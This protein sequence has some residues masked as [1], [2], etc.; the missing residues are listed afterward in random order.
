MVRRLA[1]LVLLL[2]PL[3]VVAAE[4]KAKKG[5]LG[6]MIS[7]GKDKGTILILAVVPDSP[8]Q[9]AGLKPNDLLVRIDG[10]KP[11]GLQAAVKVIQ[12]LKPGKKVKFEISRDGKPK[13]I[14]VVPGEVPG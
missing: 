10:A 2:L 11:A 5:Y 4:E 1:V 7:L 3:A 8:A 14:E 13:T 6:V 9:K 12:S